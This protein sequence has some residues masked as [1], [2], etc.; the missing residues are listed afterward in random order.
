MRG[1]ASKRGAAAAPAVPRRRARRC[2]RR[3]TTARSTCSAWPAAPGAAA[4]T[5][6]AAPMPAAGGWR[7]GCAPTRWTCA[8]CWPT[9]LGYDGLRGRGRIDAD[10]R[11][12]GATVGAVRAGAQRPRRAGAAA[13]RA[14]RRRPGADAARL[15]HASTGS[16]TVA[17][18]A[19]ARPSSAS[20]TRS[21]DVRDGVARNTDLDGRSDFL[22]VGGEGSDRPG[23]GPHRLPAARPRRQH[24]QRPRRAGDGAA[25]Q[26]DRAGG[27]ARPV[28]Q[29][30]VAGALGQRHRRGGC[31]VGAE[32]GDRHGAAAWRAAPPAWCAARPACCAAC[33]AR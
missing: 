8:R 7:C 4:S 16:D 14:A 18:D 32:R 5:P 9:P 25:E 23:P 26:R 33:P 3:S 29:H 19:A 21:F 12:R 31:A 27:T 10:L 28:R 24:R 30:R 6:A 17:S 15:A 1:C 13:G 2:R 22:R 20:S 11:S